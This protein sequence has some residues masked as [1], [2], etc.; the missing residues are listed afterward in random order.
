M[1]RS[2]VLIVFLTIY[3]LPLLSQRWLG[4]RDA[5]ISGTVLDE[6]DTPISAQI[7]LYQ[8]IVHD[9]RLVVMLGCATS[10]GAM[11]NFLCQHLRPGAYLIVA[12]QL[13]ETRQRNKQSSTVM[14][15]A[16]PLFVR[17]PAIPDI[18]YSDLIH[19]TDNDAESVI[20]QANSDLLTTL[21]V[22]SRPDRPTSLVVS[23]EAANVNIPIYTSTHQNPGGYFTLQHL[24]YGTYHLTEHWTAD[25]HWRE[26]VGTVNADGV[27]SAATT[28]VDAGPYGVT[29]SVQYLHDTVQKSSEIFLTSANP[30][31]AVRYAATVK[32]DGNFRFRSI[33]GGSYYL[34]F[35]LGSGSY[36]ESVSEGGQSLLATNLR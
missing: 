27:Q 35:A 17:Y 33:P 18:G 6:N 22:L 23:I 12:T 2:C 4:P 25:D 34:S 30:R 8:F 14:T 32:K 15:H 3:C 31:N 24:P 21:S 7:A 9:G 19:L 26:S 29:G 1:I 20:V 10:A 16:L 5:Q 11:G 36:I 28:L 13:R